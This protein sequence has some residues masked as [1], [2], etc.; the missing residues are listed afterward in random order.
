MHTVLWSINLKGR[1]HLEDVGVVRNGTDLRE[2]GWG[3][4]EWILLSQDRNQ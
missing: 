3:V 2:I 4:V 1:D